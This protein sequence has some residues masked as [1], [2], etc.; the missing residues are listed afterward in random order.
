MSMQGTSGEDRIELN[1]EES[2]IVKLRARKL[3]FLPTA[4]TAHFLRRFAMSSPR[5][6]WWSAVIYSRR[7]RRH[8]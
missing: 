5:Y 3:L 1:K 8:P 6:T 2:R 4:S 7:W